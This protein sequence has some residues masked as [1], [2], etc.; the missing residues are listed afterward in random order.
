MSIWW[1]KRLSTSSRQSARPNRGVRPEYPINDNA[2][3]IV[4]RY[5]DK[6]AQNSRIDVE[7]KHPAL[8][9]ELKLTDQGYIISIVNTLISQMYSNRMDE[10][11]MRPDANITECYGYYGNIAGVTD[12]L[13]FITI[14]KDG[15]EREAFADVL[16]QIEKLKRYG[17]TTSEFERAKTSLLASVEAQYNERNNRR[18]RNLAETE[19]IRHYLDGQPIPGIEW[20]YEFL[21]IFLPQLPVD[22][23]NQLIKNYITDQNVI[24]AYIGK[25]APTAPTKDE[26]LAAYNAAKTAE[27]AAPVEETVNRPLVEKAPKKGRIKREYYNEALSIPNLSSRTE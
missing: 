22:I 17:F 27:I 12:G 11:R 25:D 7:F 1:R 2:E 9:R 6:E 24:I 8:P 3:P 15:K 19:Y 10:I 5:T 23:A 16:T 20:E 14:A 18:N 13:R 21:K 26:I 4:G